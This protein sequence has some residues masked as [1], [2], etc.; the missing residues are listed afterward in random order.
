[1]RILLGLIAVAV[2][3]LMPAG[4]RPAKAVVQYCDLAPE[5][6]FYGGD[7]RWYYLPPGSRWHKAHAAGRVTVP[8]IVD[9][10]RRRQ[11]CA[12]HSTSGSCRLDLSPAGNRAGQSPGRGAWGC[13][14]T[15]GKVK[16]K[17]WNYPNRTAASY[18]ALA[19]CSSKTTSGRCHV[20]SC[21][22]GVH[23][24]YEA[25]AIWGPNTQQ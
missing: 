22:A 14:A 17:S 9:S 11:E 8:D 25:I 20:V 16:G 3:L 15:D 19:A 21:R 24:D 10:T 18:R 6:C 4:V 5:N 12:S 23:N 7:G 13:G 1:M 2:L